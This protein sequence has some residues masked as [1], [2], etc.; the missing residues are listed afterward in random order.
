MNLRVHLGEGGFRLQEMMNI[1]KH[2]AL[3]LAFQKINN[4]NLLYHNCI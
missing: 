3:L 4:F 2:K 1:Q